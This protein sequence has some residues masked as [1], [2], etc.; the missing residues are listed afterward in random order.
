MITRE[1]LKKLFTTN[2]YNS[3]VFNTWYEVLNRAMAKNGSSRSFLGQKRVGRIMK[4][5]NTQFELPVVSW[6]ETGGQNYEGSKH[7]IWAHVIGGADQ[8]SENREVAVVV[9]PETVEGGV[10]QSREPKLSV[11]CLHIILPTRF[12]PRNDRELPFLAIA[13]FNTWYSSMEYQKGV[14]FVVVWMEYQTKECDVGV[15]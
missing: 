12:W 7:S 13:L 6:P 8:S 9:R 5:A 2:P 1:L 15:E 10:G 11:G 14:W 3:I 4:A